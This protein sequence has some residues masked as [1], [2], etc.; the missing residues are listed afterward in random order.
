M[1]DSTEALM[2][3]SVN[4]EDCDCILHLDCMD[5]PSWY[6]DVSVYNSACWRQIE[7]FYLSDITLDMHIDV[8]FLNILFVMLGVKMLSNVMIPGILNTPESSLITDMVL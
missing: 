2:L 8:P 6:I 3:F 4:Q 7:H 5:W 1:A